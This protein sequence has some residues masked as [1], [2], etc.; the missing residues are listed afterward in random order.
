[1]LFNI[2]LNYGGRAEI[3]DAA[4]R[5]MASGLGPTSSTRATF[6]ELPLHRGPARSRSADPHERRDAHQQFPALADRLRGDLRDRHVV[7]GLPP[8]RSARGGARLP[9]ARSSVRRNQAV[10]GSRFSANDT[11]IISGVVL[12]ARGPRRP[13][14]FCP[15]CA[16]LVS[17]RAR[18]AVLAGARISAGCSRA[19]CRL[20]VLALVAAACW[21]VPRLAAA[22]PALRCLSMLVAGVGARS[23]VLGRRHTRFRSRRGRPVASAVHRS[24]ARACCSPCTRSRVHAS[25]CSC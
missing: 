14:C 11:R 8:A 16:L 15:M 10:T 24:A 3:V 19:C 1:M 20:P 22:D 4:R 23:L 9:E 5:A 17:L 25:R 18:V 7:A 12:G 21:L 2:A 13:I 6:A